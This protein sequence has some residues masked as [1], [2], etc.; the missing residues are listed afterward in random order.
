MYTLCMVQSTH[1]YIC[2]STA[3]LITTVN[4]TVSGDP[5]FTVPL[6]VPDKTSI[7]NVGE[8]DPIN[9]CFEVH[10]ED[11]RLFNL[12]SDACVS[13]NARYARVL[14]NEDINIVDAVF[15]RA[16]DTNGS[17]RYVEVAL[18]QC[19]AT[20][21]GVPVT[22][23]VAAGITVR[24]FRNRVRIVVPNCADIDLVMWVS[25]L[26]T[27][28][29]SREST[30]ENEIIFHAPNIRFTI[31]RGL[32]LAERSHGLLGECVTI[33]IVHVHHQVA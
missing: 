30:D 23:Y 6:N 19:R 15:V 32:D 27:T 29:W 26:N 16:S 14:P 4:D 5:L 10:G 21:D 20:V 24:K 7:M 12:V 31:A 11:G 2:L 9:L 28:F 25:C 3:T 22:D 8:N 1:T 33:A 17:C 18:D 13:V